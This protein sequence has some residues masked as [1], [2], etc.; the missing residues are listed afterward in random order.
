MLMVLSII[1][2]DLGCKSES[3]RIMTV[4]GP[5]QAEDMG[6]TLEHEHILVDFIGADSTGYHRWERD[7]VA[8]SVLPYLKEAKEKGMETM[9]E[10]TPAYLGRD[11][12]LLKDLSQTTNIHILTNTGYYGAVD[13]KFLPG[14]AFEESADQL[15]ER[16]IDEWENGIEN[17]GIKPGFIKISVDPDSTLSELHEKLVRAAARTHLATGLTIASHTGPEAPAFAQ[18]NILKEEGVSPEAFIWVHAQNGTPQ[19]HI[20]AVEKGAW[21]SLD[22]VNPKEKEIQ[23]YVKMLSNLKDNDLLHRTLISHDAGWYSPGEPEGGNF[24]PYTAI[25]DELVPALKKNGFTEEDINL[26]LETN[27][28]NAFE[29]DIKKSKKR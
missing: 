29:I 23:D 3:N 14:H 8:K 10:C 5:I 1:M 18:M 13:N 19:A 4:S 24:R 25:F 2:G 16:W 9:L 26:L 6:V 22:G 15:A 27:P 12:L 21:V 11:P 7:K 28:G 17:T 20:K